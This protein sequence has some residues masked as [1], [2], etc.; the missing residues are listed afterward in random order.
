MPYVCNKCNWR[1]EKNINWAKQHKKL[2]HYEPTTTNTPSQR[3]EGEGQKGNDTD[4]T[5]RPLSDTSDSE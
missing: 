5:Q 2:K 1:T 3:E 4:E